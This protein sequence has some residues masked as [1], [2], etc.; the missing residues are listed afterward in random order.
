MSIGIFITFIDSDDLYPDIFTLELMLVNAI[1][2]KVLICGGGL[3]HFYQKKNKIIILK[4]NNIEFTKYGLTKYYDYQY[5]YF[6]QRF[7]YKKNFIKKYKLYFPNYLR[8]QDPPFFIK[9]MA[10][11]K[12]FYAL[13]NITYLHRIWQKPL[14]FN[15]R[16][17]TDVYKGIKNCLDIS[18]SM[19]LY[20]SYYL[21][22]AILNKNFIII[23]AKKYLKSKRLK[24]SISLV[25]KAINYNLIKKNN[26][27][28]FLN[29][30]YN[31]FN[32]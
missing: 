14:I 19:N 32:K 9:T 30:F 12:N 2:N 8:F 4:N 1:K 29:E 13:K 22:L 31:I 21:T 18:K 24:H 11:A 20:K 6:F 17:I 23:N 5:N 27:T 3:R 28:F 10:I 16:K 25:L 7:I 15:E 26:F